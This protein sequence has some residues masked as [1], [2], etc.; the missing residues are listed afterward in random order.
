MPPLYV[1][2]NKKTNSDYYWSVACTRWLE[3]QNTRFSTG[4][5]ADNAASYQLCQ[6][7][8]VKASACTMVDFNPAA[9]S[10]K[11]MLHTATSTGQTAAAGITNYLFDR[12]CPPRNNFLF[13]F[14]I[15]LLYYIK[16]HWCSMK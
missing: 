1:H 16:T 3:R 13:Y 12:I 11:C 15:K 6:Q 4:G 2:C 14:I 7:A 5:T 10:Q 9:T 8:C